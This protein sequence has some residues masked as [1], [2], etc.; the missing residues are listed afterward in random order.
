MT[1]K[2]DLCFLLFI[3]QIILTE[4]QLPR[5]WKFYFQW[6][7]AEICFECFFQDWSLRIQRVYLNDSG[8]YRCQ[9]NSH[10]PQFIATYLSIHGNI[11]WSFIALEFKFFFGGKNIIRSDFIKK[12][13]LLGILMYLNSFLKLFFTSCCSMILEYYTFWFFN[14]NI[15]CA[16]NIV[17]V[18]AEPD[19]IQ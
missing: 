8:T 10:P 18:R 9:A 6:K 14:M 13:P 5:I 19:V 15:F 4:F 3:I 17:H 1:W 12:K 7:A 2:V 16:K 11:I